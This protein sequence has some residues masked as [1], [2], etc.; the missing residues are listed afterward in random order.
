MV[1]QSM[2]HHVSPAG[3]TAMLNGAEHV[4]LV[5]AGCSDA[6]EVKGVDRSQALAPCKGHV[7]FCNLR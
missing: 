3:G 2:L 5:L 1:F 7:C 6:N 4:Y